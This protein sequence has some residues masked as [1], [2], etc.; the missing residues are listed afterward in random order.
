MLPD[1]KLC[2]EI[3]PPALLASSPS[4]FVKSLLNS[5]PRVSTAISLPEYWK[6]D[7]L[8][9]QGVSPPLLIGCNQTHPR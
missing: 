1:L 4:R 5:F 7:C 3:V 8:S 6:C 2:E 9:G